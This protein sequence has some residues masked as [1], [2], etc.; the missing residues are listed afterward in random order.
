[1][2]SRNAARQSDVI[3]PA[4][5]FFESNQLEGGLRS[6]NKGQLSEIGKP[7]YLHNLIVVVKLYCGDFVPWSIPVRS[8]HRAD[9]NWNPRIYTKLQISSKLP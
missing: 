5:S 7:A 4:F 8:R 9:R 3:A 2:G 1:M 6:K